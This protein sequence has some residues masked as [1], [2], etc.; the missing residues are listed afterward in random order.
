MSKTRTSSPLRQPSSF[1]NPKPVKDRRFYK[2][3]ASI[4]GSANKALF[5]LTVGSFILFLLLL[6]YAGIGIEHSLNFASDGSVF[7]CQIDSVK[8][9]KRKS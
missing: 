3:A 1:G 4:L 2:F 9:L 5:P 8:S 7:S 6:I